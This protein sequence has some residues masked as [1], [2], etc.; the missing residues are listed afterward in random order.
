MQRGYSADTF[1]KIQ[2]G[3]KLMPTQNKERNLAIMPYTKDENQQT[4]DPYFYYNDTNGYFPILR[5]NNDYVP[6]GSSSPFCVHLMWI[7]KK[8]KI[9]VDKYIKFKS[10]DDCENAYNPSVRWQSQDPKTGVTFRLWTQEQENVNS[11][12]ECNGKGGVYRETTF[13]T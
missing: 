5:F 12:S 2:I 10:F 4:E 9:K 13:G 3:L 1:D 6:V 8:D 11:E 7:D